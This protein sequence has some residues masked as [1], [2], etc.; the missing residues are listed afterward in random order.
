MVEVLHL[1]HDARFRQ[2]DT[3]ASLNHAFH[4]LARL[5]R[6]CTEVHGVAAAVRQ[7]LEHLPAALRVHPAASAH[8]ATATTATTRTTPAKPALIA[9]GLAEVAATRATPAKSALIATTG[10]TTAE[11][12]P[13]AETAARLT[14]AEATAARLTT[15][16]ATSTAEAT[17]ARLTTAEAAAVRLTGSAATGLTEAGRVEAAATLTTLTA[18][19]T[20]ELCRGR[21]RVE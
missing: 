12:T 16:E 7:P 11:A 1:R 2:R 21:C 9:A 4:P 17:A 19:A 20:A 5:R 15:A 6:D 3:T 10:L 14:A 13:T 18:F 8:P